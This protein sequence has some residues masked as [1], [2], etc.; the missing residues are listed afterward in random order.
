L[1]NEQKEGIWDLN[2]LLFL[3]PICP[4]PFENIQINQIKE[5]SSFKYAGLLHGVAGSE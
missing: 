4:K 5:P 2:P 3:S 1:L